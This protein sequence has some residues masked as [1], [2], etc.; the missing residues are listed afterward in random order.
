M[1]RLSCW[2]ICCHWLQHNPD[3]KVHGA[4][5]GPTWVLV[6]PDGPHVGP[7]KLAI[8][9]D[10][11]LTTFNAACDGKFINMTTFPLQCYFD[12]HQHHYDIL[13]IIGGVKLG[14]LHY[15]DVI[16]GSIASQITSLTIVY[17]SIYSGADQRKHQSSASPALVR[18][19]HRRPV[20]SPHRWPVMRKMFPFDD[21]IMYMTVQH[22]QRW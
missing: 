19:I 9:E 5:M 12:N 15:S 8:R 22:L 20:N 13:I 1:D 18:G 7:M 11:I 10:V 17:S 3:S 14:C 6:A 2:W 16:M 21:V 4:N